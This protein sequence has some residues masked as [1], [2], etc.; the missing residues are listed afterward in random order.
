[1]LIL[2]GIGVCAVAMARIRK[3]HD[4]LVTADVPQ[5]PGQPTTKYGLQ[6][7]WTFVQTI[8]TSAIAIDLTLFCAILSPVIG[9][10]DFGGDAPTAVQVFSGLRFAVLLTLV[11]CFVRFSTIDPRADTEVDSTGL[12]K[13]CKCK[14]CDEWYSGE[15]RKHCWDCNKVREYVCWVFLRTASSSFP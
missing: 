15:L 6:C 8:F 12:P 1:M 11:V 9:V 14:Y 5:P 2:V 4:D 13:F 10:Y 7:P 3:A